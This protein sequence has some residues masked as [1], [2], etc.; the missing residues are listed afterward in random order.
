MAPDALCQTAN[1]TLFVSSDFSAEAIQVTTVALASH[2][3]VA[4]A[5]IEQTEDACADHGVGRRLLLLGGNASN[6]DNRSSSSSASPLII[7]MTVTACDVM[8][9]HLVALWDVG[10]GGLRLTGQTFGPMAY[11]AMLLQ[12]AAA[13]YLAT[14]AA[15]PPA[16]SAVVGGLVAGCVAAAVRGELRFVTT[17]DARFF[18]CV[19]AWAL[20]LASS[21]WCLDDAAQRGEACL[22]ALSLM[23]CA[24]NRTPENAYAGLLALVLAVRLWD[25]VLQWER[26][27]YASSSLLADDE[28]PPPKGLRAL[29]HGVDCVLS[30]PVLLG[31]ARIGLAP[32]FFAT[33]ARWPF[34][35]GTGLYIC[36]VF[37][38]HR[39]R[40]RLSAT[41]ATAT[42]APSK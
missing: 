31:G 8:D 12:A 37:A 22:H 20:F 40:S 32:S 23:A 36:F 9:G 1:A 21:G 29:V 11:G 15:P 3:A 35:A 28:A 27:L 4:R 6:H 5:Y 2:D 34:F 10:A 38:T 41:T 13:L 19:G 17:D 33:E 25:K 18:W 14:L 26:W 39:L 30:A 24:V 42:A 16:T 7:R